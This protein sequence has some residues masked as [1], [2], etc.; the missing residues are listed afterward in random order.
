MPFQ[1]WFQNRRTKW[2]KKEAADNALVK[3]GETLDST[4]RSQQLRGL[5]SFLSPSS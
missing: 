5:A 2:R 1:V 4:G 3:R